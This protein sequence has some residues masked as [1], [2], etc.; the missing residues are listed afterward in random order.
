MPQRTPEKRF[1]VLRIRAGRPG[2][3][4]T[5]QRNINIVAAGWFQPPTDHS[6]DTPPFGP[7]TVSFSPMQ[8]HW[9]VGTC[10]GMRRLLRAN[11]EVD[12][13]PCPGNRVPV[14]V[15]KPHST[16]LAASPSFAG[17]PIQRFHLVVLKFPFLLSQA[18]TTGWPLQ[19]LA[20]KCARNERAPY[21]A[22]AR[23]H[24]GHRQCR[25][26][27]GCGKRSISRHC[28]G[29][30][31]DCVAMD[32]TTTAAGTKLRPVGSKDQSRQYARP[33]RAFRPASASA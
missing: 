27:A 21:P 16:A 20:V 6:Y 18:V 12:S 9:T 29:S 7:P 17:L 8:S 3:R 33:Y 14:G 5:R 1:T 11:I 26:N 15:T 23:H 13:I 22:L 32:Y 4:S 24:T 31:L 2:A 19:K 10:D 28:R 30:S 25:Y